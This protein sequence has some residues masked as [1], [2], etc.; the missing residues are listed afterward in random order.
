[1]TE[2]RYH[3]PG[4]RLGCEHPV[5]IDVT[6]FSDPASTSQCQTCGADWTSIN[7]RWIAVTNGPPVVGG[8]VELFR[9]EDAP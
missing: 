8:A 2:I 4:L 3:R 9:V 1:M 5:A 7:R 6:T